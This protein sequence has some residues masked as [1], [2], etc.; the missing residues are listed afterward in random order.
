M[1]LMLAVILVFGLAAGL[2]LGATWWTVAHGLPVARLAIGPWRAE[3]DAGTLAADPYERAGAARRGEAPLAY[4][5]GLPF[6][7]ETDDSGR[8]L[9][10]A[11]DYALEGRLPNARLWSLAAF[12][13]SGKPIESQGEPIG[14]NSA[15][16]VR[17]DD[18]PLRIALSR[19]ARP[20]N[21]QQLSGAGPFVLRLTL[22]DTTIGTPLDRADPDVLLAIRREG[23][24]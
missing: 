11:C 15:N 3:P 13:P 21:W 20:G 8:P 14:L 7:A 23:C 17:M 4:G 18:A 9:D 1:R 2:G 24:R 6:T 12:Q 19:D 5:D 16:V 10:L 22:Y